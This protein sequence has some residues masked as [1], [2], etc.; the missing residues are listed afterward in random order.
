MYYIIVN[1]ILSNLEG[2]PFKIRLL[3]NKTSPLKIVMFQNI[4]I[5][6]IKNLTTDKYWPNFK[7]WYFMVWQ[8]TKILSR[9]FLQNLDKNV[10]PYSVLGVNNVA[11][12]CLRRNKTLPLIIGADHDSCYCAH[13]MIIFI[14]EGALF[15]VTNPCSH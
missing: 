8:E 1:N 9:M 3:Y 15:R 13:S 12:D 5:N 4:S 6:H 14:T 11:Y 2:D 7:I 10:H